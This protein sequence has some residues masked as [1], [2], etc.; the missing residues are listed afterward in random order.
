MRSQIEILEAIGRIE[1]S[2][3]DNLEEEE[4]DEESKKA[5][6]FS[7]RKNWP[8]GERKPGPVLKALSD[9]KFMEYSNDREKVETL[10]EQ[11]YDSGEE[12]ERLRKQIKIEMKEGQSN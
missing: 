4:K 3:S 1:L 9:L 6:V 7:P 11:G 12:K 8:Q 10:L 2:K 5:E